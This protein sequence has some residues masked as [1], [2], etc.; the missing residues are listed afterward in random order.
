MEAEENLDTAGSLTPLVLHHASTGGRRTAP[1]CTAGPLRLLE[2][3]LDNERGWGT[4]RV[5]GVI[6]SLDSGEP[7]GLGLRAARGTKT[8]ESGF[9]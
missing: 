4:I 3:A 6:L 8:M 9:T 7:D 5:S 1:E 2:T